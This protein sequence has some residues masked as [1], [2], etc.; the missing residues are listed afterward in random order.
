MSVYC[1]GP[2]VNTLE[3]NRL[4]FFVTTRSFPPDWP[5][6][7]FRTRRFN[8]QVLKQMPEWQFIQMQMVNC[9][10]WRFAQ[11]YFDSAS[12]A[13]FPT[14]IKTAVTS[15]RITSSPTRSLSADESLGISNT[16]QSN[17]CPILGADIVFKSRNYTQKS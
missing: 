8:V 15:H 6:Q 9:L 7:I 10:F 4:S 12:Q 16:G 5:I 1:G 3:T 17:T 11:M 14:C 13:V 2:T